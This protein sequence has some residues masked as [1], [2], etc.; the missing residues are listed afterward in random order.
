[1][2]DPTKSKFLKEVDRLIDNGNIKDLE[3]I[4]RVSGGPPG[5]QTRKEFILS[6]FQEKVQLNVEKNLKRFLNLDTTKK[7]YLFKQISSGIQNFS[8]EKPLFLSDSVVASITI[9]NHN[10]EENTIYFLP[11]ETDRKIQN[12]PIP[13]EIANFVEDF[14]KM[15]KTT[16]GDN[17]G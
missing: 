9:K 3:I 17:N 6:G 12:K 4:Y 1:M 14:N 8:L 16:N 5:N 13:K 7:N 11:D 15:T 10:K 2:S